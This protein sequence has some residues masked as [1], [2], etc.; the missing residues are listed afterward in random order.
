VAITHVA[1]AIPTGNP[2]TSHT[3]TIPTVA[4][5]DL[6]LYAA[7][8]R[9]AT[10][11]PTVSDNNGDGV[12][13]NNK[14]TATSKGT[15]WWKRATANISGKTLSASGFTGSSSGV[16]EALTGV[17]TVGSPFSAYTH[18]DNISGNETHGQITPHINGCWVGLS[19]HNVDND[20]AV[21]NSATTSPGALTEGNEKTS[22]GGSDCATSL[23]GLVQATA[24]ATG[25]ATWTQT[26]GVTVS[27][28]FAIMPPDETAVTAAAPSFSGGT[29]AV[30]DS[31]P[32]AAAGPSFGGGT[33]T[34]ADAEITAVTAAA[35]A[36][37]GNA[38]TVADA[39]P[40]TAATLAFSGNAVTVSDS[41]PIAAA[42]L[43]FTG[44]TVTV[45]DSAGADETEVTAAA[46]ELAGQ[47]VTVADSTPVT[48]AAT[49][50]SGGAVTVA[51]SLPV[52]AAD[53]TLAGGTVTVDDVATSSTSLHGRSVRRYN[54]R[55]RRYAELIKLY[56]GLKALIDNTP[57]DDVEAVVA[58]A[59]AEAAAAQRDD[60]V[61]ALPNMA[62]LSRKLAIVKAQNEA[63]VSHATARVETHRKRLADDDDAIALLVA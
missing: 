13:W 29:V 4:V 38:V 2:T 25:S 27:Q 55:A 35:L 15:L 7:T 52:T 22:S 46:L 48:A 53:L 8:N 18:E 33:I 26:D 59:L 51:D 36:F 61:E 30:S 24:G 42:D 23:K 56:P 11:V 63:I 57:S 1:S 54:R 31:T 5:G 62:K 21:T 41:V 32:V 44:G 17:T 28:L 20:N 58:R 34:V 60:E 40:V 37:S 14:T 50:F 9:D 49:A 6:L 45:D 12:P 39:T 19:T 10:T 3:I 16:L 43:T 47:S